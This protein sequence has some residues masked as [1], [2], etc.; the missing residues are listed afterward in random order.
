MSDKQQPIGALWIKTTKKG[1]EYCSISIGPKGQE[2]RYVAFLNHEK[3]SDTHPDFK[4]FP[5]IRQVDD[6][7]PTPPLPFQDDDI[8]F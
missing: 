4:I 6:P 3:K 8:P 1:D 2:V 5:S 7:Q